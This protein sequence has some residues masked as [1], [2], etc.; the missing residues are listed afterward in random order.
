MSPIKTKWHNIYLS[1]GK[2][3]EY[4]QDMFCVL[5]IDNYSST[6]YLLTRAVSPKIGEIEGRST[7][8]TDPIN[9]V[10][11]Q[12]PSIGDFGPQKTIVLQKRLVV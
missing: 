4:V 11:A 9:Q 7:T 10:A 5:A 1:E 3:C 8:Y 6:Y 12:L 2:V